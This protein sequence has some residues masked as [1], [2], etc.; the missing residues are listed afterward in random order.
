MLE[1]LVLQ[2]GISA[3]MEQELY[4]EVDNMLIDGFYIILKKDVKCEKG[5]F[6]K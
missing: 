3:L 1:S 5:I 6:I 2:V 4:K